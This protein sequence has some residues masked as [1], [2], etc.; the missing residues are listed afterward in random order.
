MQLIKIISFSFSFYPLPPPS[1]FLLFPFASSVAKM[2]K[3]NSTPHQVD[4][5]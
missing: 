5:S 2:P 3:I 1:T 4:S